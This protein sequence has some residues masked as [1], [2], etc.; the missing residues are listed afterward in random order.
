MDDHNTLWHH[1]LMPISCH[2]RDCKALLVTSLTH[3]NGAIAS[4]QTFTFT[5]TFFPS[6]S[7]AISQGWMAYLPSP[8]ESQTKDPTIYLFICCE[9]VHRVHT[10]KTHK[11]E[12]NPNQSKQTC[13]QMRLN[14]LTAKKLPSHIKKFRDKIHLLSLLYQSLHAI[15]PRINWYTLTRSSVSVLQK[16]CLIIALTSTIPARNSLTVKLYRTE[17]VLTFL[18][19]SEV[20]RTPVIPFHAN[21][22]IRSQLYLN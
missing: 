12:K 20:P 19:N 6:Y 5:F 22:L 13:L 21:N 10:Q 2:F 9:I 14:Q 3:V 7:F 8:G 16:Y 15:K 18:P 4:V 1:W 11:T 17:Q